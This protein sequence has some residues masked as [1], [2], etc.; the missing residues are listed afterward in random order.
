VAAAGLD[1]AWDLVGGSLISRARCVPTT[2]PLARRVPANGTTQAAARE[3]WS[4]SDAEADKTSSLFHHRRL[5]RR[6]LAKKKEVVR[7]MDLALST[8]VAAKGR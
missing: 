4:F 6:D 5:I 2:R 3:P 1:A 7:A 8:S